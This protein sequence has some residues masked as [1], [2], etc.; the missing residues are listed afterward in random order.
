MTANNAGNEATGRT[1]H[2]LESAAECHDECVSQYSHI[3]DLIAI[4]RHQTMILG[5]FSEMTFLR[6][7]LAILPFN[8]QDILPTYWHRSRCKLCHGTGEHI[9]AV[10]KYASM[11]ISRMVW[12]SA[13][14]IHQT[15]AVAGI[16]QPW[17]S[18]YTKHQLR[19]L[20][21][22]NYT[23]ILYLADDMK[24]FIVPS[25]IIICASYGQDAS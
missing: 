9:W 21:T 23:T 24:P 4:V 10:E 3:Y 5:I 15:H 16:M 17:L 25:S 7:A 18:I 14:E 20:W 6:E 19:I 13:E 22:Y 11:K 1:T 8:E 12:W 2:M